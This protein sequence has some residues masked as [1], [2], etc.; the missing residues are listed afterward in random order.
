MSKAARRRIADSRKTALVA[1]GHNYSDLAALA[2]V[3]YSMADKWMNARR[4]SE[5]CQR[6]FDTLTASVRKSA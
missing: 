2:K 5:G 1:S 6:A 4:T 3:T